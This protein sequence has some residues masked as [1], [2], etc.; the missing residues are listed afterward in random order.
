MCE[1]FYK[2]KA[3]R[4]LTRPELIHDTVEEC[5]EA[6]NT[7]LQSY[8]AQAESYRNSCIQEFADQLTRL[9]AAL[10]RVPAVMFRDVLTEELK[11]MDCM[12]KETKEEHIQYLDELNKQK[13]INESEL[14]VVLGHPSNSEK[15]IKLDQDEMGRI[16]KVI[17]T[18]EENSSALQTCLVSSS[19]S[20]LS[21][22]CKLSERSLL[23]FDS[24]T[25]T[26]DI[27][28]VGNLNSLNDDQIK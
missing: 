27:I 21:R 12:V 26:Q 3:S 13:G 15:L 4:L 5:T 11:H 17:E 20:F 22:I 19:H 25:T 28:L 16:N 1:T 18:I 10:V 2:Q 14:R 23:A 6:L 8:R 9:S 7:R 24:I